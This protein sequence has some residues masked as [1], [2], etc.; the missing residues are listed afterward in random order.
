MIKPV[1]KNFCNISR[2]TPEL[3]S[4]FNKIAAL[5]ARNFI[6][7]RPQQKCFPVNIVKF[8][9][10]A[11]FIEHF[12]WLLNAHLLFHTCPALAFR[13]DFLMADT[14]RVLENKDIN[15]VQNKPKIH[16][17]NNHG[18]N[19]WAIYCFRGSLIRHK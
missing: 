18:C 8:L 9:R 12:W 1:L 13:L 7:K 15:L 3:E 17:N 4:H 14:R 10:P 2:K 11:F 5:K 6:K 19:I 16:Q